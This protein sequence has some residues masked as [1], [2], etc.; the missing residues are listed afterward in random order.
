MN[1]DCG[2]TEECSSYE[3]HKKIVKT[4]V[5]IVDDH[6]AF[7]DTLKTLI[8]LQADM[9]VVGEAEDGQKAVAITRELLPDV[10]IMDVK[11]PVMDGVE[12]TRR[13]LAEM[14]EMK[15]LAHSMYSSDGFLSGMMK[16]GAVGFFLKGDDFDEL[17]SAI[18]K[19]AGSQST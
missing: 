8:N 7:R 13:I 18:R 14:A 16:A 17:A 19:A 5:L 10:I 15:I 2:N 6:K 12:A 9:E 11:M 3:R 4:K 1:S